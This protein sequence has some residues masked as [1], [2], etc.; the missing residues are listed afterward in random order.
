MML[1][2]DGHQVT[3]LERDPEP[4]RIRSTMPG[5]AGLAAASPSF[6]RPTSCRRVR[7]GFWTSAAAD[8]AAKL[9]AALPVAMLEDA[10][11]YRA[12]LEISSCLELPQDVVSRPGLAERIMELAGEGEASPAGPNRQE[13]LALVARRRGS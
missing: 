5:N 6:A 7:A 2:R 11:V 4:V 8:P 3:I 12:A 10:D 1:A 13:T 9:R